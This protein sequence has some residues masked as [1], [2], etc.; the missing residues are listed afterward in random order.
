LIVINGSTGP[1]YGYRLPKNKYS[2]KMNNFS[3][4]TIN[5]FISTGNKIFE[6]ERNEAK[7]TQTDRLFF[8]G[9]MSVSN[10]NFE[11]KTVKL[12]AAI[13]DTTT[14]STKLFIL[15][16]LDILQ[17]DSLKIINT[18]ENNLNIIS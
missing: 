6:Y 11:M 3:S 15:R 17:N 1:P 12:F 2:I 9:G 16:S 10:P 7:I 14:G 8:D 13:N 4:D 5:T 18:D